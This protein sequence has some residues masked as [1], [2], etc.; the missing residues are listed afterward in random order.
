M[1]SRVLRGETQPPQPMV[2]RRPAQAG[3]PNPQPHQN[4]E[5]GPAPAASDPGIPPKEVEARTAAA[6]QQ[7]YSA[8]EQAGT[9]KA[10][11]QIEPVLASLNS[12]IAELAGARQRFRAEAEEATVALAIAIA[13]RVLNRELSTDPEAILGLV[14]A[15]FQKCEAKETHRLMLS[16]AD[17]ET[18]KQN[19]G[20]LRVP[21]GLDIV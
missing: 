9:A 19:R 16:P 10:H 20:R 6:Y 15:V 11:A 3:V 14:K 7:G 13:R 4:R 5:T 2:W 12:V 18:L 1:S 21:H 8:G 17:A